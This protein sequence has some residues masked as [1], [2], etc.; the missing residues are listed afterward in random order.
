MQPRYSGRWWA[1]QDGNEWSA[2]DLWLRGVGHALFRECANDDE[3]VRVY[4]TAADEFLHLIRIPPPAA[5]ESE[6]RAFYEEWAEQGQ[7][8]A[9]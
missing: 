7:P 6:K 9:Q 4:R 5:S 2:F 3:G 8:P 1:D